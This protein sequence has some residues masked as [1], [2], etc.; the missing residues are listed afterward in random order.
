[1]KKSQLAALELAAL[2]NKNIAKIFSN[3]KLSCTFQ[4]NAEAES[5]FE[6]LA[7]KTKGII[8]GKTLTTPNNN[9]HKLELI[10]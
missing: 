6:N 4:T 3:G 5:Y 8:S 7:F 9:T 2:S 1:M 10:A